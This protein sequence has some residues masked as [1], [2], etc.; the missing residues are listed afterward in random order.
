MPLPIR[1]FDNYSFVT[2]FAGGHF[3]PND[4]LFI[5]LTDKNTVSAGEGMVDLVLNVENVLVIGQNTRGM[6][7]KSGGLH[8]Y[9]PYSGI[10][11]HFGAAVIFKPK[12]LFQEGVGFAPDIWVYGDALEAALAFLDRR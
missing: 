5:I 6:L 3:I 11:I 10:L 4:R 8:F 9:L 7:A 1:A 12:G 2:N